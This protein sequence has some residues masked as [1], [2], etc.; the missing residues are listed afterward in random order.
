VPDYDCIVV[1]GGLSG[2]AAADFLVRR[3]KSVR[4]LEARQRL[5]GRTLTVRPERGWQDCGGEFIGK[6]QNYI[7]HYARRFEL[8]TM[9]T[10]IPRDMDWLFQL[11]DG[12][13][14]TLDGANPLSFPGGLETLR[15]LIVVD[16]LALRVQSM[17]HH[18]GASL[19]ARELDQMTAAGFLDR[20]AEWHPAGRPLGAAARDA[21]TVSIRSAY[22]VEP[23]EMSMLWLLYYGAAA[24]SY[25]SLVDVNADEGT[26]ESTVFRYGTRTLVDALANA[27][28]EDKIAFGCEVQ[29]I[30]QVGDEVRVSIEGQP[31]SI[32]ASRVIVAMSPNIARRITYEPALQSTPDGEARFELMEAATMGR[33]IKGFV[34]FKRPFWR[35]RGL[36]GR[37]NSALAGVDRPL[38]W[39]LDT[40]WDARKWD[41]ALPHPREPWSLMTFIVGAAA[42]HW[43]GKLVEERKLAVVA[44][45]IEFFGDE[46]TSQLAD[47][48]Y[49]Q[50]HDFSGEPLSGGG[51]NAIFGPNILTRYG[52][53]L[54]KPIGRIH[55]AGAESATEWCGYM[56]GAL[57]SGVRAACEVLR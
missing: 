17:L 46:V 41:P 18:P 43:R 55:W 8:L 23:S 29:G 3:G 57:Q 30:T 11:S 34:A 22:S 40:S 13:M 28:G 53:A 15:A 39:T 1:G 19:G 51:P 44:H 21:L 27:I 48:D 26:A 10:H 45:L 35:E 4:L 24:G 36:S 31:A 6:A 42:D 47:E 12:A 2:L 7:N 54:R 50:E 14:L 56:N 49:Y 52:S 20:F 32:S 16:Q 5:G 9:P 38:D 33:T 25:A 37:T